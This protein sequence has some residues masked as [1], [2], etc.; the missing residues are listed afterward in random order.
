[1]WTRNL[2]DLGIG[3]YRRDLLQRSTAD[4]PILSTPQV[5]DWH[6]QTSEFGPDVDA[7]NSFHP[8]SE[9]ERVNTQIRLPNR[10]D[11]LRNAAESD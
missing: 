4:Q 11:E 8:G 5:H 3:P 9:Y 10:L 2:G 6:L 1:M 7:E